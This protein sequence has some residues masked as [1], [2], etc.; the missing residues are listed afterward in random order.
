M[1]ELPSEPAEP[2]QGDPS[3]PAPTPE[4]YPP[5]DEGDPPQPATIGPEG[6]RRR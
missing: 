3:V 2:E 5:P 4:S 1:V 6:K